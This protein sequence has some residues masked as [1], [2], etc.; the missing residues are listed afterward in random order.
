MRCSNQPHR[1]YCGVD[2]HARTLALHI[3][4]ARERAEARGKGIPDKGALL[5]A[6]AGRRPGLQSG[7]AGA[8]KG[9]PILD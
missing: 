7:T 4:D 1:F 5:S 2:L 6:T 9:Q 3:L 8:A